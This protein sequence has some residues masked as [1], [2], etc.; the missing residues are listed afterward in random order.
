MNQLTLKPT[1]TSNVQA[2]PPLSGNS[3]GGH[4]PFTGT[5]WKVHFAFISATLILLLSS[6]RAYCAATTEVR[7]YD[8]STSGAWKSVLGPSGPISAASLSSAEGSAFATAGPTSNSDDAHLVRANCDASLAQL[9]PID[10]PTA[11]VSADAMWQDTSLIL[12]TGNVANP[13]G[14]GT[15]YER[16]RFM[17]IGSSSSACG[18]GNNGG[19]NTH[20]YVTLRATNSTGFYEQTA[21]LFTGADSFTR[22]YSKGAYWE[23]T[24][25]FFPAIGANTAKVGV[26]GTVILDAPL[27]LSGSTTWSVD[28]FVDGIVGESFKPPVSVAASDSFQNSVGLQSL[29][30]VSSPNDTV[31]YTPESLGYSVSFGSGMLSPNVVP[32]NVPG[33]FNG[34]RHVTVADIQA[35]LQ[36]LTDLNAYKYGHTLTDAEL[37]SLGD[38]NG[39]G[40]VN[41]ADIQTLLGLVVSKGGGS[42]VAVPEPSTVILAVVGLVYCLASRKRSQGN[43]H[44]TFFSSADITVDFFNHPAQCQPVFGSFSP[45]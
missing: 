8:S 27:D 25:S 45:C 2:I 3:I 31:E 40:V 33:D 36:A 18:I 39:D 15:P 23:S 12:R 20:V 37:L 11:G 7:Y 28:L 30:L 22:S 38:L 34:D 13:F 16:W 19:A 5:L 29:T 41:N 35:M 17:V 44:T 4:G 14:N 6:T 24:S 42:E 43:D 10:F 1:L 21:S 9:L 26:I 32:G